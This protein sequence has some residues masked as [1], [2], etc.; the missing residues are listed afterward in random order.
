[1]FAAERILVR[2]LTVAAVPASYNC[3]PSP[4]KSAGHAHEAAVGDESGGEKARAEYDSK[5]RDFYLLL[6]L[7]HL[8]LLPLLPSLAFGDA[9]LP[10]SANFIPDAAA[11]RPGNSILAATA[12]KISPHRRAATIHANFA[13]STPLDWRSARCARLNLGTSQ[14]GHTKPSAL[15]A[16]SWSRR[17]E[18]YN[19]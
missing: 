8:L 11:A 15:D 10:R 14:I 3:F 16:I 12:L 7:L 13:Y 19:K 18:C 9:A 4:S 5:W 2:R 17:L 1:M 6:L